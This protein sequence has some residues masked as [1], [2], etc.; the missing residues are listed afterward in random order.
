[1]TLRVGTRARDL[2]RSKTKK[3]RKKQRKKERKKERRKER[4]KE[5]KEG[6]NKETQQANESR[7]TAKLKLAPWVRGESTS[8]ANRSEQSTSAQTGVP[9][10]KFCARC[11][12]GPS[13]A[14]VVTCP[15]QR[16]LWTTGCVKNERANKET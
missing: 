5:R 1:M 11:R 2:A 12:K 10:S 9:G 4:K 3:E 14:F 15:S 6:R 13:T 7:E 16:S 8:N